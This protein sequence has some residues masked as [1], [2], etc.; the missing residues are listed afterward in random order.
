MF[1]IGIISGTGTGQKRTLPALARS[2]VCQ[3]SVVHGRDDGRL[4]EVEE[5]YP[6]VLTAT[7]L[8]DFAE[9]ADRYDIVYV[10][11][12]PFLHAEHIGFA[13]D[14]DKPIL[15]EKPLVAS[16]SDMAR[17]ASVLGDETL[18]FAVA[19]QVRH[20]PILRDLHQM[21]R[22]QSHGSPR[23][24][25]MQ[26]SF[27]LDHGK[28]SA[29]WKLDPSLGGPNALFDAGIHAVDL[30]LFLFGQPT[31]ISAFGHRHRSSRTDDTVLAILVYDNFSLQINASQS[32]SSSANDLSIAFADTMV[33]LPGVLGELGGSEIEMLDDT[34]RDHLP[35]EPVDLYRATV[36]DFCE[37]VAGGVSPGTT[38][39]EAVTAMRILFAA[40]RSISEGGRP[41]PLES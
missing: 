24:V 32:A 39:P 36:E 40:E 38:L 16:R 20:Q 2:K 34:G 11:S 30:A 23:S 28:S 13:K 33:R 10:A 4:H 25:R 7:N 41:M 6:H 22:A 31:E 26:W 18:P 9:L 14:L 21:V 15:C 5:R 3:V 35:Y 29:Q 1:R 12:P 27:W 37:R 19:H 17:V 8:R